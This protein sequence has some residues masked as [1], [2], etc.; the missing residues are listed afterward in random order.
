MHLGLVYELCTMH[1][2]KT[3]SSFIS[4]EPLAKFHLFPESWS[5]HQQLKKSDSLCWLIDVRNPVTVGCFVQDVSKSQVR[6][7]VFQ[8]TPTEINLCAPQ[9]LWHPHRD[10]LPLPTTTDQIFGGVDGDT[11]TKPQKKLQWSSFGFAKKSQFG[12]LYRLN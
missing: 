9:P 3:C 11:T 5:V 10:V 8:P 12:D 1:K 7:A 4:P 6:I 2:K